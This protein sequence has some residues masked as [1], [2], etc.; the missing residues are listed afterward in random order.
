MNGEV[1]PQRASGGT[2]YRLRRAEGR[3][4]LGS[5]ALVADSKETWVCSC[6]SVTLLLGVLARIVLPGRGRFASET[7]EYWVRIGHGSNVIT[8]NTA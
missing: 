1:N 7:R 8:F 4:W 5:R 2:D 3:L 6:L